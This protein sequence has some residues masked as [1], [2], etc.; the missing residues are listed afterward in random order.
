M[1]TTVCHRRLSRFKN[2]IYN[3][4]DPKFINIIHSFGGGN[5]NG[6]FVDAVKNVDPTE[7]PVYHQL[8]QREGFIGYNILTQVPELF[9]CDEEK[10][11]YYN[12]ETR[13]CVRMVNLPRLGDQKFDVKSSTTNR[14]TMDLWFFV[15]IPS[16][17]TNGINFIYQKHI[18]ISI[19][20]E[21]NS[22][23]SLSALCFPQEYRDNLETKK[24]QGVYDLYNSALNKEQV[25]FTNAGQKWNYVRC[26][27]DLSRDIFYMNT[28]TIKNIIPETLY[29]ETRNVKSFRYYD[30]QSETKFIIENH[31]I[32]S[33]RVFL[34]YVSLYSEYLPPS[35]TDM[36]YMNITDFALA[37]F[38]P[39]V[40]HMDFETYTEVDYEGIINATY[41]AYYGQNDENEPVVQKDQ[42]FLDDGESRLEPVH[43]ST[44]PTIYSINLCSAGQTVDKEKSNSCKNIENNGN[45]KEAKLF[46]L[47]NDQHFYLKDGYIDA[48]SLKPISKETCSK[49]PSARKNSG[50]CYSNCTD[51]HLN[52]EICP[53]D[54]SQY[55]IDFRCKTGYTQAYFQCISN[56]NAENS[57]LYF[58]SF[59]SFPTLEVKL[60]KSFQ[61]HFFEFWFKLDQVNTELKRRQS[62]PQI[63]YLFADPHYVYKEGNLYYYSFQTQFESISISLYEWNN[64]IVEVPNSG[65]GNKV[66]VYINYD[67]T[68]VKA[69][70]PPNPLP[71]FERIVFQNDFLNT[72][73]WGSAW[74]KNFRIWDYREN[75]FELIK[76]IRSSKISNKF[77][78]LKYEYNFDIGSITSDGIKGNR[79]NDRT[80]NFNVFSWF[81][82]DG[83]DSNFLENYSSK[84][85]DYTGINQGYFI[86]GIN[87]NNNNF[88]TIACSP[89]CSR[90]HSSS[91]SEC[92]ECM[93]GFSLYDK[94]CKASTGYYLQSND[95]DIEFNLV[96][97]DYKLNST[98]P[99]TITFWMK[100]LGLQSGTDIHNDYFEIINF[101]DISMK[102]RP[103]SIT[104][105]FVADNNR[106]EFKFELNK[107]IA[108]WINIGISSYAN[109]NS[110]FPSMVNVMINNDILIP[111]KVKPYEI[112]NVEIK[113]VTIRKE[114]KCLFSQLQFYDNY[115]FGTFGHIT[116]LPQTAGIDLG[117]IIML[118]GTNA[119]NCLSKEN[120][121]G[122]LD[123]ICIEDYNPFEDP[124]N[125][126]QSDEK[127]ISYSDMTCNAC[128]RDCLTQCYGAFA[129]N[130]SSNFRQGLYWIGVTR[131]ND[132]ISSYKSERI[133][134]INFAYYYNVELNGI[135]PSQNYEMSLEFWIY[136]NRY[137][138]D[139][140]TNRISYTIEV[141]WYNNSKIVIE[142][143]KVKCFP[144]LQSVHEQFKDS[145]KFKH[146][147]FEDKKWYY[148]RCGAFARPANE[149]TSL[150]RYSFWLKQRGAP[151][152][153]EEKD[154]G[155]PPIGELPLRLTSFSIKHNLPNGA[156]HNH[157][158]VFIRSIRLLSKFDYSFWD[159]S[160][161]KLTVK[162]FPYLLHYFENTYSGSDIS[163]AYVFDEVSL[164]ATPLNFISSIIGYNYVY[165]YTELI[166]CE[167]KQYYTSSKICD[168]H[169]ENSSAPEC[170]VYMNAQ[171]CLRCPESE[172]YLNRMSMCT[173]TCESDHY[174][175]E[176]VMECRKCEKTCLTCFGKE[177]N[178]C[179]SCGPNS[180]LYEL[181]H[182]C[183][184]NCTV[185]GLTNDDTNRKCIGFE[186]KSEVIVPEGY[187]TKN[188]DPKDF[189]MI[190]IFLFDASERGYK[191]T[192]MFNATKTAEL[193]V[194]ASGYVAPGD[195]C[196][197]NMTNDNDPEELYIELRNPEK[198]YLTGMKY[199]FHV[200][201]NK[202][203]S[204]NSSQIIHTYIFTMNQPP[205]MSG[206]EILPKKG[207]YD[208]T[209]FTIRCGKC[210]DDNTPEEDIQYQ[211]LI[212][213]MNL[214]EYK[215]NIKEKNYIFDKSTYGANNSYEIICFCRDTMNGTSNTSQ[216]TV[217]SFKPNLELH[218]PD[219]EPIH[220]PLE[221][222]LQDFKVLFEYNEEDTIRR[223]EV[224][225]SILLNYTQY[226]TSSLPFKSSIISDVT[227]K[228]SSGEQYLSFNNVT[229]NAKYCNS[230][231]T[232]YLIDNY[233]YCKCDF[234]FTG[235]YCHVDKAS[236]EKVE[237]LF[238]NLFKRLKMFDLNGGFYPIIIRGVNKLLETGISFIQDADKLTEIFDFVDNAKLLLN[239]KVF[240]SSKDITKIYDKLFDWGVHKVNELKYI[241]YIDLKQAEGNSNEITFEQMRAHYLNNT[242][243]KS[244]NNYFSKI[245]LKI[246]GLIDYYKDNSY[247]LNRNFKFKEKHFD[248]YIQAITEEFDYIEYFSNEK[249]NYETYFDLKECLVESMKLL[250]EARAF[251][252]VFTFLNYKTNP[253][254]NQFNYTSLLT[255]TLSNIRVYRREPLLQQILITS[256]PL[257]TSLYFYFPVTNYSMPE[258]INDKRS[259]ISPSSSTKY[260]VFNDPVYIDSKGNVDT[261]EPVKRISK[262]FIEFNFSCVYYDETSNNFTN[263]GLEFTEYSYDNYITCSSK[264]LTE[265]SV[266]TI[267]LDNTIRLSSR[268]FY[269][270]H[271]MLVFN[272]N[273]YSLS[274]S[275]FL[276]F[277]LLLCIIILVLLIWTCC[278]S[279]D[280]SKRNVL[281]V[282]I[283]S[284]IRVNLPY[285]EEYEFKSGFALSGEVNDKLVFNR[286]Q[287]IEQE[288]NEKKEFPKETKLTQNEKP[289]ELP[290]NSFF[291]FGDSLDESSITKK[292]FL[293]SRK[294]FQNIFANKEDVN[295]NKNDYQN[296][297]F[298]NMLLNKKTSSPDAS[299]LDVK[300]VANNKNEPSNPPPKGK[301]MSQQT[302]L[303]E[304]LVSDDKNK[305]LVSAIE[306]P[307]N[308]YMNKDNKRNIRK[309]KTSLENVKNKLGY[310]QSPQDYYNQKFSTRKT[311]DELINQFDKD[312]NDNNDGNDMNIFPFVNESNPPLINLQKLTK[313]EKLMEIYNL[314]CSSYIF[315]CKNI[316]KRHFYYSAVHKP[317][318]FYGKFKRV[319]NLITSMSFNCFCLSISLTIGENIIIDQFKGIFYFFLVIICSIII[320]NIIVFCL[321]KIIYLDLEKLR[322]LYNIIYENKNT[323]ILIL[324]EYE[325][326][327]NKMYIK[328]IVFIV[329]ECLLFIVSFY[330][331]FGFCSTYQYQ[332]FT[333]GIGFFVLFVLDSLVFEFV[334]E[335][336]ITLFYSF[337]HKGEI[338]LFICAT[339]NEWRFQKSLV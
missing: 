299:K 129:D 105:H 210:T 225:E 71:T 255:S 92:Y 310:N 164:T 234:G 257:D 60:E 73:V 49:L 267:P 46:C 240:C 205:V 1:T 110:R 293:S 241:G 322:E 217:D 121:V 227:N 333:F 233:I 258:K 78:V 33:T 43:Y 236:Y 22:A 243:E 9:V 262:Y 125:S 90:C 331:S 13:K 288:I 21:S 23:T 231:G 169:P 330:F 232:S 298:L 27:V 14:Y 93:D 223:I 239:P 17:F 68:S 30:F 165:D 281:D 113:G 307:L 228:L 254:Y 175:D 294:P 172:P 246:D 275:A 306:N 29:G 201:T 38:Y 25:V 66:L 65:S 312:N 213:N 149:Y 18:G 87:N 334:Y 2:I 320:T 154:F 106:I 184:A 308:E 280:Y 72:S 82:R 141:D 191:S 317:S 209:T 104:L 268:F 54:T 157:A 336:I 10:Y 88:E 116:A 206:V 212:N 114:V 338:A 183:V 79:I 272:G 222:L 295:M 198:C 115:W 84:N 32:S 16:M 145:S 266:A 86:N 282:L 44:Y 195:D 67:K 278:E 69:I 58:N 238:L 166:L 325:N 279:D 107:F 204:T 174:K 155:L 274:N 170:I 134:N 173:D 324:K 160:S 122:T 47:N 40:F 196:F 247:S 194:N 159:S 287:D 211:I 152:S 126:C 216:S 229:Q 118:S 77:N 20:R 151:M 297:N 3:K 19:I 136:I 124:S 309:R 103:D 95:T 339:L 39:L 24:M 180:Y 61:S 120:I 11:Y 323:G 190:S 337:R 91:L 316:K 171:K 256:C 296:V 177:N 304:H 97:T 63:F 94:Q 207:Y 220:Y 142:D 138:N 123:V 265:F 81:I 188:F 189:T 167:N 100:F 179:L 224:F 42:L 140:E 292:S 181:E 271:Y 133:R 259:L 4:K 143:F 315:F 132:Y 285:E 303:P 327:K 276:I 41:P 98:L 80:P 192:L 221:E 286:K 273:N 218:D 301:T 128:D 182:R 108:K 226:T 199:A 83:Y 305:N 251:E 237:N 139:Y 321:S 250:Y 109:P 335:L 75:S 328:N 283:T 45:C 50:Y 248:I 37:G 26:S 158:F 131:D 36:R 208:I 96:G 176:Y 291:N 214:T 270:K 219:A 168:S 318:F 12:F 185:Y 197:T 186:I 8:Q 261:I 56:E 6:T 290:K 144:Y 48:V 146:F 55:Y 302:E 277:I 53:K 264:H 300:S 284:L 311:M 119:L 85:F 215:D 35:L 76:F 244:M 319:S 70:N 5:P 253:Y 314:K 263:D 200:I 269:L 59:Y 162:D 313:L 326:L 57:A 242:Q 51:L 245:K 111:N 28:N 89:G 34:R 7:S 148:I 178:N 102:Y 64:I 289:S 101:G 137:T 163:K 260:S 161:N 147:K 203:N 117:L 150:G 193:N 230:H 31:Q 74:Y 135:L 130:C 127:I 329:L 99:I 187:E 112:N 15:E 156:I 202:K 235:I 52:A 249:Q 332:S 62:S 252:A 153:I